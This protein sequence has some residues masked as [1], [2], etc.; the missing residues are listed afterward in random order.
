M[1]AK[2]D[3]RVGVVGKGGALVQV[4]GSVGLAGGDDLDATRGEQGAEAD[5]E[6]EV[7]GFFELTA[8]E[9]SAGVV[10]TVGC[11]EEDDET[12]GGWGR[13]GWLRRRGRL[14]GARKRQGKSEEN[15][16]RDG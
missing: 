5:V 16:D 3:G 12:G 2:T 13:R 11:V 14:S 10:A 9:V 15:S 8:I 4:E 7:G 6:G 1:K